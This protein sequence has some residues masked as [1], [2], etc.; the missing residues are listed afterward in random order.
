[1]SLPTTAEEAQVRWDYLFVKNVPANCK[2]RNIQFWMET[3][4]EVLDWALFQGAEYY[5]T[6]DETTKNF[7]RAEV[8]TDY[9]R[10]EV[11]ADLRE[12]S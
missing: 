8:V 12:Q 1:M 10:I 11:I 7:L 4:Q 3:E 5:Y 6:P 9:L 2:R